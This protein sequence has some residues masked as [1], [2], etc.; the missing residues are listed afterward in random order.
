MTRFEPPTGTAVAGLGTD[1]ADIGRF[2][3]LLAREPGRVWRHWF[4]PA[5]TRLCATDRHPAES[6][7][8]RFAVKEATLKA[9]GTSFSGPVSWR[10]IEVLGDIRH[11]EIRVSGEIASIAHNADIMGFRA[12]AGYGQRWALAIVIAETSRP[13]L[14]ELDEAS[15]ER[16]GV[17]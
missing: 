9:V 4:T 7:A 10:D 12:S 2:E 3:R 16:P 13:T 5:E 15:T 8:I 1:I 11:L 17:A 14:E 6:T